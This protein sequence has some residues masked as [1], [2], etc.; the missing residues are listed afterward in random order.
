MHIYTAYVTDLASASSSLMNFPSETHSQRSM[1]SSM[2]ARFVSS[3]EAIPTQQQDDN[4][5]GFCK[6]DIRLGENGTV[7]SE[8]FPAPYREDLSCLW[9]LQEG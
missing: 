5:C 2:A 6:T 7:S 8:D 1:P 3:D 9:L 4:E